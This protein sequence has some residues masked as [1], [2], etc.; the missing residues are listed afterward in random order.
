MAA[1]NNGESENG[2]IEIMGISAAAAASGENAAP[3]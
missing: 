3:A 2:V 1:A